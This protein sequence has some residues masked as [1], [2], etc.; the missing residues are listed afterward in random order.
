MQLA[1]RS[2]WLQVQPAPIR[3]PKRRRKTMMLQAL[4]SNVEA[5]P[6]IGPVHR[7]RHA[8]PW[9]WAEERRET[10]L[11]RPGSRKMVTR[12]HGTTKTP[13]HTLAYVS[14]AGATPGAIRAARLLAV[15]E[16]AQGIWAARGDGLQS[17][18]RQHR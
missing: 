12:Q 9:V 2:R 7:S 6:A 13:V 18:A 8:V 1:Y 5:R 4:P 17:S 14:R 11:Y 3:A 10:E 16:A 15:R